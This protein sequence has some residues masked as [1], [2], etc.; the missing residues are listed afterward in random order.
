M[1]R[2]KLALTDQDDPVE[3]FSLAPKRLTVRYL[4][5]AKLLASRKTYLQSVPE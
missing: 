2:K 3:Q 4:E 1:H 5:K